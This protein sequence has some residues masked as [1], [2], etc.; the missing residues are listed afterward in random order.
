M[1]EACQVAKGR[2]K[3]C[4]HR[5]FLVER[6]SNDGQC[7]TLRTAGNDDI[8]TVPFRQ[9]TEEVNGTGTAYVHIFIIIGVLRRHPPTHIAVALL[10]THQVIFVVGNAR[11]VVVN[12]YL[13]ENHSLVAKV[14]TG[15]DLT[16]A[17]TRRTE[18]DGAASP[19][20]GRHRQIAI[21][22]LLLAN[23]QTYKLS[24]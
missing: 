6:S 14:V 4:T 3:R 1:Q 23:M 15:K 17:G 22:P 20:M 16:A 24:Y 8:L 11:V 21:Y 19:R 13:Q 9:R 18:N 10:G 2:I 5:N 12:L 7:P